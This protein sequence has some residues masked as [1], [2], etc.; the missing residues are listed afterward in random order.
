MGGLL[1][2]EPPGTYGADELGI[3]TTIDLAEI[4]TGLDMAKFKDKARQFLKT[5]EEHVAL[6]RLRRGQALTATDLH[7][8]ERSCETVK[9]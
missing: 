6:Q 2:A 4:A 9:S 7:E 3:E 8:L 1:G 5:R